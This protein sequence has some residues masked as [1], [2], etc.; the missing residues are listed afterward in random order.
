MR[1]F[2]K[3]LQNSIILLFSLNSTFGQ[4]VNQKV[5]R[6]FINYSKLI[7][8]KKIELALEYSNPKLFELFPKADMKN[9]MEAVYKMPNID[10]K[11][12]IPSITEIGEVKKNNNIDYIKL[13][14]LSLIEMKFKD[15]EMLY[16]IKI[17]V[18]SKLL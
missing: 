5:E 16:M 6:D 14:T 15:L 12:R 7:I 1:D 4:N 18:S 8:E 10:Y 11:I 13:K 3:F 9:L 2:S 17:L